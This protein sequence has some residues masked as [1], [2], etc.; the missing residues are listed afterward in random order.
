MALKTIPGLNLSAGEFVDYSSLVTAGNVP[1]HSLR[2]SEIMNKV[3]V[4][5]MRS[6][7]L[8]SEGVDSFESHIEEFFALAPFYFMPK[9]FHNIFGYTLATAFLSKKFQMQRMLRQ[10]YSTEK[11]QGFVEQ[12]QRISGVNMTLVE[13][14]DTVAQLLTGGVGL[15]SLFNS[16]VDRVRSNYCGMIPL[17]NRNPRAFVLEHARLESNL[18]F[19]AGINSSLP[20]FYSIPMAN[21][22]P[23]VFDDPLSFNPTRNDLRNMLTWNALD[24]DFGT[25][26]CV[27]SLGS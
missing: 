9:G 21:M 13:G 1:L 2:P 3:G 11:M 7:F 6:F 18:G 27:V 14:C 22:D 20:Q 26:F 10:V 24:S 5:M 4:A 15:L 17:W 8:E 16:L 19:L 25:H 23:T 12:W